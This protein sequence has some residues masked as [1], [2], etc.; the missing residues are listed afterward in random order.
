V[1][2]TG[3]IEVHPLA[4]VF[5]MMTDDELQD[6]ADDIRENGLL[7]PIVL[8]D[9]GVLIDG[10]N[11]LRACEIAGVA[12]TF[13][14]LNGHDAAA[15]IVSANLERRN[16][17]K[18]QQA[19][20]LAMIYPE[21]HSHPRGKMKGLETKQFDRSRLSQARAVLHHSRA[22]AEDV[23]GHR[24]SLDQALKTVEEE[25]RASQST[26]AKMAELRADAPDVAA[27]VDDERLTLE[28]G[29]TELR[30]R[31]MQTEAGIEAARKAVVNIKNFPVQVAL[32]MTGAALGDRDVLAGIDLT[33]IT[34]AISHLSELINKGG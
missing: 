18:G 2:E 5:P 16:L 12:P 7:H 29:M 6:L 25:R 9:A 11:R 13:A 24:T 19:V 1:S 27:L 33:E 10:R 28:A 30:T 8:D 34:T 4:A 22:L 14:A 31:R 23:L 21:P 26:D 20:A 32:V 17:T 3:I 15:F